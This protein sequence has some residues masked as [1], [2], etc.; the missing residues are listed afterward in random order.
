MAVA[1]PQIGVGFLDNSLAS[2]SRFTTRL[3][4]K[5]AIYSNRQSSDFRFRSWCSSGGT[6]RLVR[7]CFRRLP[8]GLPD[9]P[10]HAILEARDGLTSEHEASLRLADLFDAASQL[11]D[12]VRTVFGKVCQRKGKH[13]SG[14]PQSTSGQSGRQMHIAREISWGQGSPAALRRP[15]LPGERAGQPFS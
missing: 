14:N 5:S 3:T 7:H 8:V 6:G 11:V 15:A 2:R 12:R 1:F 13:R 9:D 4:R 10:P